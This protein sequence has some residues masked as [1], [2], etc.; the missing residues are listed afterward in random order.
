MKD[1][2]SRGRSKPL[3]VVAVLGASVMWAIEPILAK[4]SYET[5]NF[6]NTFA[7]RIIFCLVVIALYVLFTDKRYFRVKRVYL[8]KLIYLSLA[9]TLFADLMYIYAL[10]RVPVINAVLIGHMQPIFVILIGFLMLREDRITKF[11]YFGVL[12]MIIAGILVTTKTFENLFHLKFGTI[13]DLYV[14]F[15]TIAWATTAIVA[16]KY[17]KE[18]HAATIA[19]YRFLFATILFVLYMLLTTGIAVTN[20]YQALIGIVVGIGTI[21]YYEGIKILKAAQ[22]SALEL[23]TPFFAALLSFLILREYVSLMQCIGMSFLFGGIY[24][25]SKREVLE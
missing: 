13:G 15:A 7:T 1:S 8:P 21:L 5:T 19:F 20:V 17:L 24:F 23:S 3:G 4:L 18:L 2:T 12:C 9:A 14:L 22:V 25:L 11:D 10:T 16:R 6:L